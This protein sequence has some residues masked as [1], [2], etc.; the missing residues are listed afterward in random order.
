[1]VKCIRIDFSIR[2][3]F[4]WKKIAYV[5]FP[6]YRNFIKSREPSTVCFCFRLLF[7]L[8]CTLKSVQWNFK[9]VSKVGI[10]DRVCGCQSMIIC[11]KLFEWDKWH[12]WNLIELRIVILMLQLNSQLESFWFATGLLIVQ[13]IFS[14]LQ[15]M[16]ILSLC[17]MFIMHNDAFHYKI[18]RTSPCILP[19]HPQQ[20]I[21]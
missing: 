18:L 7:L 20:L 10:E 2:I 12:E 11:D 16:A 9:L 6:A 13:A 17:I 5:F 14:P 19:T 3:W 4:T 21:I 15:A 1:M 8:L